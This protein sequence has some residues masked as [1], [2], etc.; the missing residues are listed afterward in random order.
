MP[1]HIPPDDRAL[2]LRPAPLRIGAALGLMGVLVAGGG[3]LMTQPVPELGLFGGLLA[4]VGLVIGAIILWRLRHRALD[5]R[6]TPEGFAIG[7]RRHTWAEAEPGF[8]A[9]RAKGGMML[10]IAFGPRAMRGF[11]NFYAL[12]TGALV[13]LL[14]RHL[15]QAVSSAAPAPWPKPAKPA[16]SARD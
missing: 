6:I 10:T 5:L 15:S 1:A 16:K 7:R 2:V 13:A 4:L 3:W 11:A 9:V 8:V 12:P 14:N